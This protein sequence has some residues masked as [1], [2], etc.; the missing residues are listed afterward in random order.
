MTENTATPYDDAGRYLLAFHEANGADRVALTRA[1]P[2]PALTLRTVTHLLFGFLDAS[3]L[4]TEAVIRHLV[5]DA[6]N[7]VSKSVTLKLR[8]IAAEL[9]IS[10]EHVWHPINDT[11]RVAADVSP[12]HLADVERA[13]SDC[14]GGIS[15]PADHQL[16][17]S[18]E[19]H[20]RRAYPDAWPPADD[21]GRE[22][23]V[24]SSYTPTGGGWRHS[25]VVLEVRDGDDTT[26]HLLEPAD[27]DLV[28]RLLRWEVSNPRPIP[29]D[30]DERVARA[31]AEAEASDKPGLRVVRDDGEG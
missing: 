13:I 26:V 11:V 2:D 7:L 16:W 28:G 21:Q 18:L 14:L 19:M 5:D 15:E 12:E 17:A 20:Y 23:Y 27:A 30:M 9:V 8:E 24:T 25:N 4:D 10:G 31:D 22:F 1:V 6:P 29:A 3:G